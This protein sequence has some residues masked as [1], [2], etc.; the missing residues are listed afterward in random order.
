[1][2]YA[3]L[4]LLHPRE[5]HRMSTK[6]PLGGQSKYHGI[7]AMGSSN[8][9]DNID[10]RRSEL[11]GGSHSLISSILWCATHGTNQLLQRS[12]LICVGGGF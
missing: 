10:M 5:C 9:E 8:S 6:L 11:C 3:I 1:M 2:T 12:L 7:G 4:K